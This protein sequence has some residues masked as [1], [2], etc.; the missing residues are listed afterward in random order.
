MA[1][2]G[3][4]PTIFIRKI[5]SYRPALPYI[6]TPP[7]SSSRPC[8]HRTTFHTP[9]HLSL[10]P[11]DTAPYPIPSRRIPPHLSLRQHRTLFHPIRPTP[12]PPLPKQPTSILPTPHP[13]PRPHPHNRHTRTPTTINSHPT[14]PRPTYRRP[15]HRDRDTQTITVIILN[16]KQD[17]F[18]K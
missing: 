15:H 1:G 17:G 4:E 6:T 2:S 12:S 16:V 5:L 11:A 9:P 10:S 3:L 7:H 13:Q 14:L 18:T 8:Q